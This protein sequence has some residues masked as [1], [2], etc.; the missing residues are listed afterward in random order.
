MSQKEALGKEVS[1]NRT[2]LFEFCYVEV[3]IRIPDGF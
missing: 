3:T 2:L 1:L